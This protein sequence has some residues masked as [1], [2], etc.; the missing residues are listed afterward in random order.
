MSTYLKTVDSEW[1]K[2]RLVGIMV[3][4]LAVF[5]VL[6][7][8]LFYLQVLEGEELRR[9]S[10]NNCIRLQ[11]IDPPRGL[12]FDR[13][14][15]LLV[16]NR[17]AYNLSIVLRDA[18]P[19]A[20]TVK[21]LSRYIG[22]PAAELMAIVR[23]KH[24]SQYKPVLLSQDLDRDILAAIEVHQYDLPGVVVNVKPR[25]YYIESNNAAH[26]IGYLSEINGSELR[27]GRYPGTRS[28]D[29]IGKFGVEKT[30]EQYLRGTHGGCQVEVD[31]RGQ[32]VRQLKTV[33]ARPGHNLYLTIDQQLQTKAEALLAGK[34]GAAVAMDPANG[35]ILAMASSPSFDQNAFVD[36]MSHQQ[37]QFLANN[38]YRP[39][40]NKAIQAE[41]PPASTYKIITAIA[42]LEEGVIDATTTFYCPGYLQ[43]GD[44]VFRCW[45][46]HGHGNMKVV[47]AIAQSCDVFFYQA[48][49]KLGIDRL[50][51]YASACGLGAATGV[52][53]DHE[54]KGLVPSTIWKRRRLGKPWHSGETLSVAIGQG[55]NLV[56]PLQMLGVIAAV[57][58]GGTRY[59]PRILKTIE[60]AQGETVLNGERE[61]IG[62]L[63]ISAETLAIVRKGLWEAVN[64]PRGTA[65]RSRLA[66][67]EISGKTGTAQVVS[68]A[69]DDTETKKEQLP[70]HK[71]HAWFV[72]FAPSEKA[73]I[74][75]SVI[76]EHGEHGAS[77]AAPIAKEMI[78]T[79]LEGGRLKAN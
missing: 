35:D 11:D 18:K 2:Q 51:W 64:T 69:A 29:F 62:K 59:R 60:T 22:V 8:R 49:Q 77:A 41:Y 1:Y 54:A 46:K 52:D 67:I 44:R 56:T 73:R 21:K 39:M 14:G 5:L 27:S 32:V 65:F 79:Y 19:V 15:R 71:D 78:R 74:A 20:Q 55:Y 43:Y 33:Y 23:K 70:S 4:V 16:D 31:A 53:L 48:G 58:D 30:Y 68:M 12:I 63:P 76:L 17:P 50:A 28:G 34:A 47:D 42:A 25:R 10:E 26:M 66:G 9:L 13:G 7:A 45:K 24:G 57:A 37:W 36:G 40:E 61:V 6:F 72:A 75:V 3:C 38:A